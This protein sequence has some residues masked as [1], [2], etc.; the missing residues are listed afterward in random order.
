MK[1]IHL[2]KLAVFGIV[3][4]L[5]A[6]SQSHMIAVEIQG[7][8][9]KSNDDRYKLYINSRNNKVMAD[10]GY[11]SEFGQMLTEDQLLSQLNEHG[12]LLYDKMSPESKT[13]AIKLASRTCKGT[14]ECKGQGSCSSNDHSC[15][16]K[17]T[18][19]GM[20]QCNFKDKNIALK[21][22]QKLQTEKR[23]Q[24]NSGSY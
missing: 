18:C 8:L 11:T 16:G 2:K 1:H 17:N 15:A 3:S 23:L 5:I 9:A 4:G 22:A 12:K 10:Q 24:I 14:N 19:Y 21:V 13:L 7:I 6:A 20:S